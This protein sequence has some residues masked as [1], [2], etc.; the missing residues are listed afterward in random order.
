MA[1]VKPDG[2]LTASAKRVLT[3][4]RTPGTAPEAAE[5]ANL[6]LYFVRSGLR[7]L[8]AAGL[9]IER[10]GCFETTEAGLTRL[11]ATA[12]KPAEKPAGKPTEA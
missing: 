11:E 1:G 9:L 12:E 8:C 4:L 6:P 2:T 3:A 10:D 7:E 5:K